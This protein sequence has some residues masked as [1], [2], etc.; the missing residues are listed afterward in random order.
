MEMRAE[1]NQ[2]EAFEQAARALESYNKLSER[3]LHVIINIGGSDS[4]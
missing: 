4:V 2:K 3:I 1:Q